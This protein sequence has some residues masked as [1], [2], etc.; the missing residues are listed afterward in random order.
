M[1][2]QC[3]LPTIEEFNGP[4]GGMPIGKQ[5]TI[6][7]RQHTSESKCRDI[8]TLSH[9]RYAVPLR[10]SLPRPLKRPGQKTVPGAGHCGGVHAGSL[11]LGTRYK[12]APARTDCTREHN[13]LLQLL[14]NNLPVIYLSCFYLPI[15]SCCV[16]VLAGGKSPSM[17]LSLKLAFVVRSPAVASGRK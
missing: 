2:S 6:V 9:N 3:A 14:I 7:P 4:Q 11:T 17:T 8:P 13:P 1:K 15:Y 12:G 10:A 16:C 5:H